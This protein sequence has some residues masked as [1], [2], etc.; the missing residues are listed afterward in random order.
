MTALRTAFTGYYGMRNFGDD[1]FGVLCARAAQAYWRA[2]PRVVGPPLASAPAP[3]TVPR[4][5]PT[6][7]YG[8]TGCRAGIRPAGTAA[9]VS[10]ARPAD[11]SASRA[12]CAIAMYW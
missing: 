3:G 4:R 2:A 9:P 5:Y 1:L 12:A 6:R 11:G 10:S 8:G 7:W